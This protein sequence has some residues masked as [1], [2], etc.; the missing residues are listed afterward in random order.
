MNEQ[1][2]DPLG[3]LA[4]ANNMDEARETIFS[5][6]KLREVYRK[7]NKAIDAY[8]EHLAAFKRKGLTNRN[9]ARSAAKRMGLT[10]KKVKLLIE[11]RDKIRDIVGMK[12]GED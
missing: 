9:A 6:P 5:D 4:A 1:P 12:E 2:R 10:L 11:N 7:T 8:N 3:I